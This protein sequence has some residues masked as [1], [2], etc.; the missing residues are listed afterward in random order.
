MFQGNLL[1]FN[2][3]W[4]QQAQELPEFTDVRALQA[5]LVEQG[6]TPLQS[7][8]PATSGPASMMLVDPDGNQILVDQH[9]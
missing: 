6:V 4:D 9:R 5:S 2:P 1:T 3:G 8:D 7:A